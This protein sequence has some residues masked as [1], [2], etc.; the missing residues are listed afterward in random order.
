MQ[1]NVNPTQLSSSPEDR[2]LTGVVS[3][4]LRDGNEADGSY[5]VATVREAGQRAAFLPNW[6]SDQPRFQP[7][8][9]NRPRILLSGYALLVSAF[10]SGVMVVARNTRVFYAG[11]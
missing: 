9:T 1:R 8:S 4:R 10:L 3:N 2:K 5:R 11:A 7:L 6:E